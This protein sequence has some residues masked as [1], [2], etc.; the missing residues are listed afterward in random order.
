MLNTSIKVNTGTNEYVVPSVEGCLKDTAGQF[1]STQNAIRVHEWLR[2]TSANSLVLE[3]VKPNA[4]GLLETFC[5]GNI[6]VP[7]Y[8]EEYYPGMLVR[9]E[10]ALAAVPAIK[11]TM[12][13]NLEYLQRHPT[14]RNQELISDNTQAMMAMMNP[15]WAFN[16]SNMFFVTP[17]SKRFLFE[18]METLN[19]LFT[20]VLT[21]R[22]KIVYQT[23]EVWK[24]TIYDDQYLLLDLES[25]VFK[26]HQGEM[27]GF[28]PNPALMWERYSLPDQSFYKQCAMAISSCCNLPIPRNYVE[29]KPT[30]A[31]YWAVH[32]LT[33]VAN[34]VPEFQLRHNTQNVVTFQKR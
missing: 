19:T 26:I 17:I 21:Q 28:F 7:A 10:G 33:K 30:R 4:K 16:A 12:N 20:C 1:Y 34:I 13:K 5:L 3:A 32:Q 8:P 2:G 15:I 11:E 18:S 31:Y 25:V 14:E 29:E 9:L 6:H 27:D 24:N 23:D 22:D